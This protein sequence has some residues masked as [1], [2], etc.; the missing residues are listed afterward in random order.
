[1]VHR[2]RICPFEDLLPLIPEGQRILD[3]GCGNGT[4]LLLLAR[5]RSPSHLMGVDIDPRAVARAEGLLARCPFARS[6]RV[7]VFDGQ[8]LP[9]AVGMA[10]DVLLVDVLHHVHPRSQKRFLGMLFHAMQPGATLV[11][12][13]IDASRRLLATCNLLHDLILARQKVHAVAAGVAEQWLRDT[14]FTVVPARRQRRLCYPHY[15]IV[16][17]KP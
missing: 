7:E 3:V 13:D 2:P 8:R 10:D 14:G 11:L 5:Y 16:A 12:K 15:T 6:Y 1:M 4:F 9:P 17:R